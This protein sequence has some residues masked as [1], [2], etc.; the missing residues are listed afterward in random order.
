VATFAGRTSATQPFVFTDTTG[1][2]T[3]TLSSIYG[4][5]VRV[6]EDYGTGPAEDFSASYNYHAYVGSAVPGGGQPWQSI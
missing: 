4:V 1:N 6:V 5:E 3:S 2:P